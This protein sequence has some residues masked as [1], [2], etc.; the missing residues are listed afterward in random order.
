MKQKIIIDTNLTMA[1]SQFNIDIY[2]EL[3]GYDLFVL[4]KTIDELNKLKKNNKT[5]IEAEVALKLLERNNVDIIDTKNIKKDVDSILVDK[6]DEYIIA[7]QDKELQERIKKKNNRK[8]MFLR[9]KR[10]FVM[11]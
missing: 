1:P 11:K 8:V 3:K 7:T 5:K 6:S 2:E 10:Y 9:Q 4:D